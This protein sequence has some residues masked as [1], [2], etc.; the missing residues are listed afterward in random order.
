V[1]FVSLYNQ[2]VKSWDVIV[3]GG[4]IIGVSLALELRHH[5][6]TV[7]I[8]ERGE[9]GREAS[10]AGA[11][12][13]AALDPDTRP[14][15]RELGLASA[16]L[17]PEFIT[18]LE[19]ESGMKIDFRRD[20]TIYLATADISESSGTKLTEIEL[21]ALEPA[22]ESVVAN[23]YMFQED[24]VDPRDIMAAAMEVAK[25]RGVEIAKGSPATELILDSNRVA[26]VKTTRTEFVAPV[27]VNCCG[28][29]SGEVAPLPIPTRPVKGQLLSVVFPHLR[30]GHL[31]LRHV[32]RGAKLVY[33]VPR[34]DGRILIGATVEEAGFDKRV[35]PDT[36]QQLHQA[37]ANLVPEIGEAR[38]HESW[39]GLRPGTPDGLPIMGETSLSGYFLATGHYRNGILLAPIT[40]AIMSRLIRGA[41]P[42][43]DMSPYLPNRLY[44]DEENI[45]KR[46]AV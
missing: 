7:L 16:R 8:V 41:N 12:M 9:P 38:I 45:Q 18:E 3:I 27:V 20:G 37:A 43:F 1:S 21:Q 23:A 5:G 40:A 39:A 42:E 35:D 4:G 14:P 26:G 46:T 28:A 30:P 24:S 34:S 25:K 44:I 11:G 6:A 22:L 32:V 17:Y 13:L 29:W 31:L 33:L 19:A 15:L 2:E 36:I 10:H